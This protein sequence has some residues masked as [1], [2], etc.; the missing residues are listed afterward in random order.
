MMQN[1]GIT[2]SGNFTH[3]D[4]KHLPEEIDTMIELA[5]KLSSGIPFVR[6]DFYL[7]AGKIYVGEL[8]F[9]PGGGSDPYSPLEKDLEIASWIHL[10][11]Y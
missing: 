11:K 4:D 5:E 6:V 8:T 9:T 2:A 1:F 7:V 3:H 10:D